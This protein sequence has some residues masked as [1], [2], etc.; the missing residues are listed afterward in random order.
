MQLEIQATEQLLSAMVSFKTP[1]S[2]VPMT[3]QAEMIANG[4]AFDFYR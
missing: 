4:V 1:G 3:L 2:F